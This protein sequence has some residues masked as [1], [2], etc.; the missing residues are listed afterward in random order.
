[1][2]TEKKPKKIHFDGSHM[3]PPGFPPGYADHR[4]LHSLDQGQICGDDT[5]EYCL[6]YKAFAKKQNA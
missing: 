5:C 2:E 4:R 6:A 1:M 3:L